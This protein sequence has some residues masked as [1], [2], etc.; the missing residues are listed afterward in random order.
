MLLNDYNITFGRYIVVAGLM[1]SQLA[2]TLGPL[3]AASFMP[4]EICPQAF[5]YFSTSTSLLLRRRVRKHG[6]SPTRSLG[7]VEASMA[8]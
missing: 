1:C 2:P 6:C 4:G 5:L 7:L 8:L 3:Y